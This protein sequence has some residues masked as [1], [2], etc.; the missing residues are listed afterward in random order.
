MTIK[1]RIAVDM[2]EVM[3]DSI[4]RFQEWYGHDFQL[5]LTLEALH[6]K[7]PAD[8]VA[9]EHQAALRAYPNRPGFFKDLPIMADC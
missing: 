9:P 4:A 2:D 5:E 1:A 3:A 6:G 7:E 8:A